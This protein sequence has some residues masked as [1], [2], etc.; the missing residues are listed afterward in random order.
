LLEA[1]NTFFKVES[2]DPQKRFDDFNKTLKVTN[3]Q[4]QLLLDKTILY[5]VV[6]TFLNQ[7]TPIPKLE[8][9]FNKSKYTTNSLG[10]LEL[11]LFIL[12]GDKLD[13]LITDP[14][15][16]FKTKFITVSTM[17]GTT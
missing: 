16:I 8:V 1:S 6:L 5:K 14:Y 12:A 10:I 17:I 13:F 7:S 15:Q 4:I 11:N 9:N 3:D 2:T